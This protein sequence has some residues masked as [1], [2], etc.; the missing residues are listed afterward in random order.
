VRLFVFVADTEPVD[1]V[2]AMSAFVSAYDTVFD[3]TAVTV[4]VP[5]NGEATLETVIESPAT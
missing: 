5:L 3:V 2:A 1:D 4:K